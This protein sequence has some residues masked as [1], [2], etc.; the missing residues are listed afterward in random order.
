MQIFVNDKSTKKTNQQFLDALA[1]FKAKL[2]LKSIENLNINDK[3][4]D[5]V[6]EEVFKML[7]DR[8]KYNF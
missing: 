5:K 6:L 7:S 8:S 3:A 1:T 4:K 2:L